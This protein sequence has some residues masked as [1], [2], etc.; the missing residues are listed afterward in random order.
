M[1]IVKASEIERNKSWRI[2]IY[3]K[4]GVGKTS[5]ANFLKGKTL[6]LP[7]DNSAKVL[8]DE[9]NI[10]LWQDERFAGS[11]ENFFDRE[12]PEESIFNFFTE[13]DSGVTD[14]NK[15]DNLFIDN[16]SSFEKDWFVEKGR[17]SKNHISNELQHYSQ[18]TNYFAR[19]M[20]S[21]YMF[22]NINIV[23]T[24]WESQHDVTTENGQV[25]SQYAPEIRASVR[26]G[27]LGLADIVGR[28]IINPK[29]SNRGVLLEGNDGI[30]A[31][32]RLDKRTSAPIEE[33]FN[34]GSKQQVAKATDKK[35][36]GTK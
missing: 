10:D 26:D 11:K 13:V 27:L 29:T 1:P 22:K 16:V 31:K 3:G 21:M 7:L 30:Y 34:F 6:I 36:E 24:A 15:Y 20:T 18:W 17:T 23:T 8:A 19:V 12:K 35:K 14:L 4:P 33:L 25:F 2:I 9:D 28:V 5:S 32:N